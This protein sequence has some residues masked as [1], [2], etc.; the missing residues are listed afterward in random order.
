M[1]GGELLGEARELPRERAVGA[2]AAGEERAH[3]LAEERHAGRVRPQEA[4]PVATERERR[5]RVDEERAG[6]RLDRDVGSA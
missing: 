4:G 1:V 3:E 6:R 2:E 5:P